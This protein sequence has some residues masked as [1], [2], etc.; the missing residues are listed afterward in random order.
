LDNHVYLTTI[1]GPKKDKFRVVSVKLS[2]GAIEWVHEGSTENLISNDDYHSRAAMTSVAD[3]LGV[4]AGFESGAIIALGHDGQV[5][6]SKDLFKE[7]GSTE[8]NHGIAASLA[9]DESHVYVWIQRKQDPYVIAFNKQSGNVV[10]KTDRPAGA[11]WGSPVVVPMKDGSKHLVLSCSGPAPAR[12]E[13]DG[14]GPP[15]NAALT[16]TGTVCGLDLVSGKELWRV[17]GLAGNSSQSVII[18]GPGMFLVGASAGR[19]GGPSKEAIAS[20][21]LIEVDS[22]DATYTAKFR[23]RSTRAT[24]GFCSPCYH[25]GYA[26]YADRRGQ[27][28]CFNVENGQEVY[29]ERLQDSI[30]ATPFGIGDRVYFPGEVGTT[31]IIAAGP[32]FEKLATNVLWEDDPDAKYD[33]P[34]RGGPDAGSAERSA[35]EQPKIP[36]TKP[37]QYAVVLVGDILLIRRGDR[38][39]A[40][41]EKQR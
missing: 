41:S 2:N 31:H 1:D 12:R 4:I 5:R 27:V 19:E 21:G 11:S 24:C 38:L 20:N 26:Y 9:Q 7:F 32:K 39:Y 35:D 23:W 8:T 14:A 18:A 34:R 25:N 6:W 3:E 30:W 15:A 40:I 10:W 28:T 37:R 29:T 22:E 36:K 33:P 17:E 16:A 13:G